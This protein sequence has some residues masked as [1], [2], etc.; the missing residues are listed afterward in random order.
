MIPGQPQV[1]RRHATPG[2]PGGSLHKRGHCPAD[3]SPGFGTLVH[4][5]PGKSHLWLPRHMEP[6]HGYIART[7]W[8]A[9][10]PLARGARA[11]CLHCGQVGLRKEHDAVQSR[12]ARHHGRGKESPSSIRTAILPKQSRI[13]SRPSAPTRFAIST[14][15]TPSV[16]SASIRSRIFRPSAMR[17]PPP[18][19]CPHS[20]TCGA[21]AGDRGLNIFLFHGVMALLCAPRAT[22]IDLPRALY[23]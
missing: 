16:R 4:G 18:A 2:T 20:S 12:D 6:P 15:A 11:A 13:A 9:H 5:R 14:P 7:T 3:H 17:S 23:R 1:P 21:R 19:W 10:W 8:G 22:L